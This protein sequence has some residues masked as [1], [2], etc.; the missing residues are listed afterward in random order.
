MRQYLIDEIKDAVITPDRIR[1]IGSMDGKYTMSWEQFKAQFGG[2]KHDPEDPTTEPAADL[3]IKMFDGSW[4][5]RDLSSDGAW[6][7]RRVPTQQCGHKTFDYVSEGD[8]PAGSWP[9][10][11]LA[12]LNDRDLFTEKVLRGVTDEN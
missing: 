5:E 1:W 11:T 9:W 7:H 4:Y 10:S 12:E 2:I 3:V 8:S 6:V